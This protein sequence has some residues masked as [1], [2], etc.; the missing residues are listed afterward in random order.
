M[1]FKIGDK[2]VPISKSVGW[3]LDGSTNWDKAVESGQNYLYVKLYDEEGR[4]TCGVYKEV[5]SG[6]YFLESD[7]VHYRRIEGREL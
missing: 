3:S 6:D 5:N 7:L 2:V 4:I 1:K